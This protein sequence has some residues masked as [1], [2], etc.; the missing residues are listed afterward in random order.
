MKLLIHLDGGEVKGV[1]IGEEEK[2][3]K[4]A[5]CTLKERGGFR[6]EGCVRGRR[7]AR[8]DYTRDKAYGEKVAT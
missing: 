4:G 2:E 3:K 7:R 6:R 1:E 8:E 5:R